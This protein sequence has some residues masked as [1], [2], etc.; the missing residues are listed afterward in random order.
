MSIRQQIIDKLDTNFNLIS[1]AEGYSFDIDGHVYEWRDLPLKDEE[2]PAIIYRDPFDGTSDEDEQE[3]ELTVE[4]VLFAVGTAS[5]TVVR[6][7]IADILTNFKLITQED[8]VTGARHINNEMDVEHIKKRYA[9]AVLTFT[10]NYYTEIW[11][12]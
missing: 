4:V 9:A 12:T 3:H 2:L 10:I 11:G 5:P 7:M 1:I 6:V 8:F